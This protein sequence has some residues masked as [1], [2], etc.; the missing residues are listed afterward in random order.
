M[1]LDQMASCQTDIL[2]SLYSTAYAFI[3][4][5]VYPEKATRLSR[6]SKLANTCTQCALYS[7]GGFSS[8]NINFPSANWLYR[9]ESLMLSTTYG[10]Y[11]PAPEPPLS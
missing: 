2:N 7:D 3:G 4:D 1:Q 10:L 11:R 8:L 6:E 9:V 5:Q